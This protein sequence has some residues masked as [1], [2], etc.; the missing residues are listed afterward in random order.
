MTPLSD[1]AITRLR[2]QLPS[3][4]LPGGRYT[5]HEVL[6]EGGMG[7]VY[8]GTDEELQREVAV[9][10]ARA[11]VGPGS[12]AFAERLRAEARVLAQLEHPGIVPVHDAGL[13]PDGRVYHVMKRVHGRTLA[14]AL[15]GLSGLDRR[16]A[17]LE[18]VADTLAF[19]HERGLVHRDLKPANIMV[20]EFGE[21]L[22]MDWGVARLLDAGE[23]AAAEVV[24][25]RPGLTAAGTVLGTPG[26]MAPEQAAGG[27][28]DRRADVYALGALLVF[29]LTG[30]EPSAA[31]P[32][33]RLLEQ[34]RDVPPPLRA[35]AAR[36]LADDP[37]RRYAGAG[38]VAEEIRRYRA[39]A[40]VHAYQEHWRERLARVYRAYRV[41]ILLVLAYL[42][43]RV[44]VAL[45]GR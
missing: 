33:S 38:D 36:C 19:A 32:A 11:A 15:P 39:D 10:V 7:T 18:H 9:K 42:V 31:T 28:L 13:L 4:P 16:L 30:I 12:A 21:V 3:P 25:A 8:R 34:Q 43:M 29:L 17:V 40:R 5:L 23:P 44:V 20:G 2:A 26:F 22:V 24:A 1:A 41:P 6:G 27:P 45:L 37:A 35:L 14:T